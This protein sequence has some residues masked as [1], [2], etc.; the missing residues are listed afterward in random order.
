M[1]E[2]KDKTSELWISNSD[3]TNPQEINN[4]L[5]NDSSVVVK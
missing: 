1:I 5:V 3:Y 2:K 4:G